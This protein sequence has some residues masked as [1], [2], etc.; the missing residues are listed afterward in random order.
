MTDER[1]SPLGIHASEAYVK[2]VADPDGFA[3]VADQL[4]TQARASGDVDSLVLALRAAAWARRYALAHAEALAL[5]D[6][7]A[8]TARRHRL[9]QRLGAVLVTRGAVRHE[10]GDVAGAARD[11]ERAA[12][13]IGPEMRAELASQRGALAQNT[14]RLTEA[15]SHYRDVLDT[16]E[17]PADVRCKAANNLGMLEAQCGRVEAALRWLETAAAAAADVGPAYVAAVA[18]TRAWVT[19]QAGRLGEGVALFEEARRLASPGLPLG[20]LHAEYADALLDL[21]LVPEAT[22]QARLAVAAFDGSGVALMAAE[23]RLRLARLALLSG[24]AGEAEREAEEAVARLRQQRR[25]VWAARAAL[26]AVAARLE[27]GRPEARDLA[28]ARRAAATLERAGMPSAAVEAHLVAGH[29]ASARGR[30]REAVASWHR[31]YTSSRRTT[32][33]VRLRGDLAAALAARAEGRTDRVLHHCRTGLARLAR[34]RVALASTELRAL[35][36]GHGAELGALGLEAVVGTGSGGRA[37]AWMERTR[38][39]AL[40]AVTPLETAGAEEELGAL[41]AA[42]AELQQARRDTGAYPEELVAR[43]AEVEERLRR[44]AWVRESTGSAAAPRSDGPP[45]GRALRDLLDGQV[46]VEYDVL[47]GALLAVVVDARSTRLVRL[48]PL[49][50]V[51]AEVQTLTALLRVLAHAG[52]VS[53]SLGGVRDTTAAAVERLTEALVGPLD[54]AGEHAGIVVVPVRDLEGVPWSAVHDRPVAV[55]PSAALWVRSRRAPAPAGGRTVLVAGPDLVGAEQEV[56]AL[57]AVHPGAQLLA[58]PE[59]GVDAVRESLDG[60]TLAHLACHGLVRTD[61]PT[62][63]SLHLADGHL[64]LHEIDRRGGMPHRM[65]LAA[66][67]VG[68]GV[69]L[70]GNE[71]LG[72]AG[73][74]LARGTAGLVASTVVVPDEHVTPLMCALHEGLRHGATVAAALHRARSRVDPEDPAVFPAWCA[75]TAY[76]GA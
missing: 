16:P 15:A 39:A 25:S 13:L 32:V 68:G 7:A 70:A 66:C 2:V 76:G 71:V 20:E 11:L 4:V 55:S 53:R 47:D 5:L 62:F 61:N 75:F 31:A 48:G 51:R 72:F 50:E 28:A 57:R 69:A 35:A 26:V 67:D 1:S 9:D 46:L 58:P 14:G 8:R 23:A 63:S 24:D 17:A 45:S 56:E 64:T 54:L 65:V 41:R 43:Q 27:D 6:E 22:E 36:S 29:V 40:T 42:H 33:L 74:L 73:T 37:L 19:V 10:V 12:G 18:E 52:G 49:R 21:R 34:H 3:P 60:A 44:A 38:A 59:S 30:T